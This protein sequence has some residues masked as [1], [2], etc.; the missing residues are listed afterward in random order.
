MATVT[1]TRAASTFPVYKPSGAGQLCAAYGSYNIAT[2]PAP[3]DIIEICRIPAGAVVVG[4]WVYCDDIDTNAT[5]TWDFDLG[6]AANGGSGTYDAVD[7]D[8]FGNFGVQNGDAITGIKPEVGTYLP[9]GGILLD[10]KFPD[11]TRETLV[12]V[13]VVDDTATLTAGYISACILYVVP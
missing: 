11:F 5:E 9:L 13:T 7:A 4:G 3:A 6:W 8:G 1:N 2:D 10:G 12:Q